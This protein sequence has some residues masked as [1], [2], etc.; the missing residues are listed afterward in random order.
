MLRIISGS[1]GQMPGNTIN[2]LVLQTDEK[3]SQAYA[4]DMHKKNKASYRTPLGVDLLAS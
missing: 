4:P 3:K 1:L 2:M